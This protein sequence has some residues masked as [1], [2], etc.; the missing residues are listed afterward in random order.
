[1]KI[2]FCRHIALLITL[3]S[4]T[5]GRTYHSVLDH[6]IYQQSNI[7]LDRYQ[8]KIELD[9]FFY[10]D[11]PQEIEPTPSP[12]SKAFITMNPTMFPSSIP[13]DVPSLAPTGPTPMP[14]RRIMN[15]EGNGG[16]NEGTFLYQVNMY[17]SWGDGWAG[18]ILMITGIEDETPQDIS[19]NSLTETETLTGENVTVTIS[20]T[21][22]LEPGHAFDPDPDQVTPIDPLGKVFRGGL[23]RGS[24]AATGVCLLPRRCYE[25][26]TT[27]GDFLDEISWD[28]RPVVL[29]SNEQDS[30]PILEG[31]APAECTF[32]LPDENG[33]H[34][35][36]SAC[37]TTTNP[38]QAPKVIDSF[39]PIDEAG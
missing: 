25:V 4:F 15:V 26:V 12:L 6:D 24:H 35:C 37:T 38:E 17:D 16:C 39:K 34:F 27:G 3:I 21:V 20:N 18:T 14:T 28:I 33:F 23:R 1:M 30:S 32:S 22:E 10:P 31:G 7:D 13:S 29:G 5:E 11:D 2:C 8:L 36:P 19:I 9:P